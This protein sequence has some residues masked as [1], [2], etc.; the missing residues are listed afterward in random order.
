MNLRDIHNSLMNSN[1]QK[2]AA[3]LLVLATLFAC[4]SHS[5][6]PEADLIDNSE[7]VEL[8]QLMATAGALEDRISAGEK[9]L[10]ADEELEEENFNFRTAKAKGIEAVAAG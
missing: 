9:A 7:Q 3:G 8:T 5:S 1:S 2:I 6:E 4:Q 10:I